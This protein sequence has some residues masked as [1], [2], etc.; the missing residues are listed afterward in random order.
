M[1]GVRAD[2][3]RTECRHLSNDTPTG[4]GQL[5]NGAGNGRHTIRQIKVPLNCT[6]GRQL[7]LGIQ[8]RDALRQGRGSAPAAAK[9]ICRPYAEATFE[10]VREG[11]YALRR[12]IDRSIKAL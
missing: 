3:S 12:S 2:V 9:R 6:R 8:R 1:R 4:A 10:Y 7:H 5:D 11:N